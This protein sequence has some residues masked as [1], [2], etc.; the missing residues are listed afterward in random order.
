MYSTHRS[1]RNPALAD[2]VDAPAAAGL[3]HRLL[4]DPSTSSSPPRAASSTARAVTPLPIGRFTAMP[5]R[6]V[7]H[8]RS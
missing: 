5:P 4:I 6:I 2:R 7:A 8:H 3:L 1:I